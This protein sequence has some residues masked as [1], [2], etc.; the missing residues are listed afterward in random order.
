M[1]D[2]SYIG[3][4]IYIGD[5]Y[6]VIGNY[7]TREPDI[8][9]GEDIQVVISA[10]TEEEYEDF[11]IGSE[12]FTEQTW[13][14]FVLDDDIHAPIT[15]LVVKTH[16]I[17]SAALA[18]NKRVIVHCAAGIS[19]SPSLVIGYFMRARNWSYDQ[20]YEHVTRARKRAAP[21]IGFESQLR[22]GTALKED[23]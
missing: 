13:H 1:P 20:A 7:D 10:L 6:S 18:E 4:G 19:R 2:Y 21:N 22:S 9:A 3:D 23:N 14:R 8:L 15:D 17:L 5:V 11:M 16:D 12:D